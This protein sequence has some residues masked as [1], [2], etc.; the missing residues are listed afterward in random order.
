M[1]KEFLRDQMRKLEINYGADKFRINQEMFDLW[2]EMSAE[3][4]D[5]IFQTAIIQT[6]K[7]CEY[8]PTFAAVMNK[9][10]EIEDYK[11]EM[12]SFLYH[13]YSILRATWGENYDKETKLEFIRLVCDKPKETRKE[14]AIN[15]THEA[16]SYHHEC[17]YEARESPKL[18]DYLKGS[19]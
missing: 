8:A 2:Y 1:T 19:R 13:Q 15:Y 16:V 3:L 18:I 4:N 12:A 14:F 7:T 9:Y 6:I 17:E 11:K 10:R 5:D